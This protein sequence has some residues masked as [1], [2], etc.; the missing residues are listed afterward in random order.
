MLH[1]TPSPIISL[2]QPHGKI[3]LR[4]PSA[5]SARRR[6]SREQ[7]VVTSC[8]AIEKPRKNDHSSEILDKLE[9]VSTSSV[10]QSPQI[11]PGMSILIMIIIGQSANFTNQ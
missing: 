7:D 11:D 10:E 2:A 9:I 3:L 1:H 4:Q 5:N 6:P 8:R